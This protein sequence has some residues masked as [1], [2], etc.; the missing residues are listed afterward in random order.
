MSKK[1]LVAAAIIAVAFSVSACSVSNQSVQNS[2]VDNSNSAAVSNVTAPDSSV[3]PAPAATDQTGSTAPASSVSTTAPVDNTKTM[4]IPDQQPQLL[5]DYSRAILHTSDGDITLKFYASDSPLPVN[6]FLYLAKE[7]FYNGVKFHRV[8]KGFMIQ[9]GDPLS[10]GTDNSVWGTGGPGYQF[11][12]EYNSRTLVT[13]AL[14]MAN[15]GP[16]TNGSQFFIVT[17]PVELN[18]QGHYT[19]FGQVESGMEAVTKI[20]NTAVLP[21]PG[22]PA[23]TSLPAQDIVINSV[24]LLK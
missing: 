2:P 17:S 24:D 16:N 15:A 9:S 12:D 10:K 23:E 13:G 18:L 3:T 6:N 19:I 20:E 22:N 7:G 11:K 5:A 14:A 8:I 4:L 1:I 21:N